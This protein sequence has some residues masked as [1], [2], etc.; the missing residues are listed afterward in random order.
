[1]KN[2]SY[3]FNGVQFDV[4]LR[5]QSDKSVFKEIFELGEYKEVE[6][7][8]KNAKYPIID[9]GAQAG[10]FILYCKA[11]NPEVE[12]YALEPDEKNLEAI[13]YHSEINKIENVQIVPAALANK[14]GIREFYLS[15]DTHNHSLNKDYL[16]MIK[17]RVKVRGISFADLC[18]EQGIDKVSLLKLDIEG[19]EYEVLKSLKLDDWQKI[20]AIVLEYHDFGN[21]KHSGLETILKQNNYK[22]KTISSKFDHK[23]GFIFATK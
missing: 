9:A 1:M 8:I 15:K 22:I 20:E 3:N 6:T 13:D 11:L 12:I 23:L 2:L 17:K 19:A 5:S 16:S 21:N 18:F 10:F 14:S 7:I 4:V